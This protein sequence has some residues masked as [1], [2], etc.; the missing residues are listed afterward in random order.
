M[1]FTHTYS[2][3]WQTDDAYAAESIKLL[4]A[5]VPMHMSLGNANMR[6]FPAAESIKLLGAS[7][8]PP[9]QTSLGD[10]AESITLLRPSTVFY[11]NALEVSRKCKHATAP[12]QLS[13]Q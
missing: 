7:I 9:R 2:C 5:T 4:G 13:Q 1:N 10:A 3:Y 12:L 11:A 6:R 8:V